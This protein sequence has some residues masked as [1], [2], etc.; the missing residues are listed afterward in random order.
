MDSA[1]TIK[2]VLTPSAEGASFGE[3]LLT[4]EPPSVDQR[5]PGDICVVVDVSGSMQQDA[6][7]SAAAEA[8]QQLT[9]LDVVQH[10]IKTVVHSMG[11]QDRLGIVSFSDTAKV[12]LELTSMDA[13]GI[14]KADLAID[15][16][17]A[18]G[19]T[20][21]WDGLQTGLEMLRKRPR[22]N[23]NAAVL[24][25][26]DG[27]PNMEPAGG[28]INALS[29]YRSNHG[30]KLPATLNTFGFGKDLDSKLLHELACEGEGMYAFIPDA[31]FVGTAIINC[32]TNTLV[33]MAQHAELS[34]VV[35][36]PSCSV[37]AIYGYPLSMSIDL[38][39]LQYGQNKDV[40][41]HVS[42][43]EGGTGI[44]LRG[45]CT[46]VGPRGPQQAEFTCSQ[47]ASNDAHQRLEVDVQRC[48]LLF[49]EAVSE[50]LG[51]ACNQDG[52]LAK[53]AETIEAFATTIQTIPS[54]GKDERLVALQEDVTGQAFEAFSRMD[55][56]MDWGA[57]YI[58]SLARAHLLQQCNNFKDPGVQKYGG[59]IFEKVR[60]VAD[61]M[62][63][64]LPPPCDHKLGNVE[65]LVAMGFADAE[66]RRALQAANNNTELA[67][68]YLME[69]IPTHRP[70]LQGFS[71]APP[72][73]APAPAPPVSMAHYYDRHAG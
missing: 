50:A 16:M 2:T 25:L 47:P 37:R 52:D 42:V 14:S 34:L 7:V 71:A 73:P 43:P 66:V 6:T 70:A 31:T 11:F 15:G 46:Y 41:L 32:M 28:H 39:T 3:V 44:F 22:N 60:E 27:V 40:V 54:G 12:V 58:R 8:G 67:A 5:L 72:A 65:S 38:G 59:P 4:I 51:F 13:A 21:L 9:V 35:C 18:D 36:A 48:R 30:S 1:V 62:F 57:H 53:A 29:I 63:L 20:N 45:T 55:W 19:Q 10:A 33:T 49:T 68:T 61:D 17:R 56:F 26:T 64:S 24:L 23:A 69:G